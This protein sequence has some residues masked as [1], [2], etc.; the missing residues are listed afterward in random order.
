MNILFICLENP[1]PPNGGHHIR[2][3]NIL[4]LLSEHNKVYFIAIARNNKELDYVEELKH[5]CERIE[6]FVNPISVSRWKFIFSIFSNLVSPLP[7]VAQKYFHSEVRGKINKML[8]EYKID[9]VHFDMLPL[10]MYYDDVGN[11]PK[12]LTNHNVESLRLSRWVKVEKNILKKSFIFY[13]YAKLKYFEKKMCPKFDRCVV[14]SE[15][16]KEKLLS[17]Y[18]NQK[19]NISVI[20]NGVDINYF[21]LRKKIRN[22]KSLLWIGG[23]RGPYS[24]DAVNYFVR[25]IF[26]LIINEIPDLHVTFIGESPTSLLL[27]TAKHYNDNVKV[28]GFIDDVRSYLEECYIFIAPIRSGSG[29]K[30]KVLN[31]LAFEKPVVTTTIGAEGIYL[32]SGENCMIADDP[33][34]FAKKTIFLLRNPEV[35]KRIGENGRKVIEKYYDWEIIG[36]NMNYL[37]NKVITQNNFIN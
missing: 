21:K 23:M 8:C 34:D 20:P 1:Y 16:D 35:A 14:V 27:N 13:Q 25:E 9:I 26:P 18:K 6:I 4:K 11:I 30:I 31:A 24:S 10:S 33:H 19:D 29:T 17:M 32:T 36:K 3:Y 7:Y 2:T 28:L 22:N 15:Y 12:I 37:Y 5:Y